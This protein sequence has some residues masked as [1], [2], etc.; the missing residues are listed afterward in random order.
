MKPSK[1]VDKRAKAW[2]DLKRFLFRPLSDEVIND[3]RRYG[4]G[5]Y[6]IGVDPAAPRGERTVYPKRDGVVIMRNGE[7]VSMDKVFK[8]IEHEKLEADL[9]KFGRPRFK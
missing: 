1:D 6:T 2:E 8:E 3:A 9:V 5:H 4:T 7:H